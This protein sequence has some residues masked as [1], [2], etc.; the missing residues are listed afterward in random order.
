MAAVAGQ[1]AADPAFPASGGASGGRR[2][3]AEVLEAEQGAAVR[4]AGVR[5]ARLVQALDG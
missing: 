2:R 5:P 4:L 1:W 3:T